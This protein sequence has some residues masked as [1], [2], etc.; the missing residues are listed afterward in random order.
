MTFDETENP[1]RKL[2]TREV[3]D[4]PWIRVREDRVV[5]PDGAEGIY[6]VVHFKNRAVG[7]LA[8]EGDEIYLV[9]QYRY[10]LG[11]Y[12]WEIPEGGCAE[13]EDPLAAAQRELEEETGLRARRWH[14]LGEAHLS[15]SVTDEHAVWYVADGLEPGERRPEGTERLEVRRVKFR[16]ALRMALA[17]EMTDSLSLLALMHYRLTR[18]ETPPAPAD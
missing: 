12:S 6:G 10:T 8:F 18:G 13:D 15:N 9:G 17:G 7:V 14:R 11:R 1:W 16:E 3:Y 4:N 2:S 5:R